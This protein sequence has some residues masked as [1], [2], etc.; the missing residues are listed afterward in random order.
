MSHYEMNTNG[1]QLSGRAKTKQ[2]T[3][4]VA[5]ITGGGR[6]LGQ[7][8]A[9]ALAQ[10]GA[11]VAVAARSA[12]QLQ[13]T[14]A[15]IERQGGRALA[16]PLDVTDQAAVE[17]AVETIERRLGP[18]DIL[19]NNAGLWGPIN[20]VWEVDPAQWWQ[21][22]AIHI[23]GSFLCARAV[24]PNMIARRSGWII[25]IVSHAGVHRWPTCSAYA[26]SKT[27]VIKFTENLAAETRRHGVAVFALHPG[28]ATVGLT[29]LALDMEAPA[30]SPAGRAA[31]W[32][33]QQMAEGRAVPPER[34]AQLVVK[35]AAGQADR[36]SGCY[37]TVDDNLEMLVARAD[38][39]RQADLYT[40]GLRET[41]P[42]LRRRESLAPATLKIA[43][44][45]A[46]NALAALA[47]LGFA[48]RANHPGRIVQS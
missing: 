32:I 6:G 15:L 28:L 3:G 10:A 46:R 24:L 42:A 11:A 47:A 45:Y 26:V 8:F 7:V 48:S 35:L 27:A 19:V 2:L 39:I 22:M 40:L 31:A 41:G 1:H 5:L 30:A 33:R 9:Q 21:T 29:R 13:E 4:R 18:V 17:R 36:L 23:Q 43:A 38:E 37:L 12:D 44:R 20:P 25:N 34:S 14:V 16:V